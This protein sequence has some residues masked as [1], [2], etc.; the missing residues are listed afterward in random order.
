MATSRLAHA[1]QRDLEAEVRDRA[2]ER[3]D[4]S[5]GGGEDDVPDRRIERLLTD[6][7]R[8]WSGRERDAAAV[9]WAD[10]QDDRLADALAEQGARDDREA[11]RLDQEDAQRDR[12]ASATER[13]EAAGIIDRL[14]EAL[15]S[16]DG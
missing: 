3:R 6:M 1:D 14:R 2:A 15:R 4:A 11:S 9:N 13:E 12:R 7:D 8:F 10:A 5:A 16:R